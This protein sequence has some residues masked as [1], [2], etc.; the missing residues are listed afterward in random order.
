MF[1]KKIQLANEPFCKTLN[2]GSHGSFLIFNCLHIDENP[3]AINRIICRM[4]LGRRFRED[5]DERW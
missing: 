2:L 1:F 5:Y 4:W 3:Y